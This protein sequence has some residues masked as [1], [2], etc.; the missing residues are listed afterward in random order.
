M[1]LMN[2]ITRDS[3]D[4]WQAA[5]DEPFLEE[6]GKGTLPRDRFLD[7]IVQDSIYLRDYMKAFAMGMFRSPT[8]RD[9]QFFYSVLGF[10]NDSENAT[11]LGYLKDGGLSD[12]DVE[13]VE[14]KKACRDYTSF[15]IETAENGREA[16]DKFAASLP[17]YYDLILMDVQMPVM[18]GHE[19]T[20]TIRA[21]DRR[22]AGEIPILAMTANAFSEDVE[23]SLASGMNG[24]ISKP[25]DLQEVFEKITAALQAEK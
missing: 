5:A 21:L 20:R 17:G 4:L 23:K 1:S 13:K 19:A 24:H 10:V 15:L 3:M 7:Y 22:D 2:D 25:I 6:L 12:D 18:D 9:M 11:R 16:V 8:L 14:K